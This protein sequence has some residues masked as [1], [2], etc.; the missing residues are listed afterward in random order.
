SLHS[1]NRL[2]RCGQQPKDEGQC[3]K[4]AQYLFTCFHF[5]TPCHINL[6]SSEWFVHASARRPSLEFT[7]A[8]PPSCRQTATS[9]LSLLSSRNCHIVQKN[10]NYALHLCSSMIA[11]LSSSCQHLNSNFVKI[12]AEQRGASIFHLP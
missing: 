12:L 7:Q 9:T 10:S 1:P 11:Q 8:S 3:Q 2:N 5:H 6:R 4:E